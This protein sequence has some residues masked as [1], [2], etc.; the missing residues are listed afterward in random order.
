MTYRTYRTYMTYLTDQPPTPPFPIVYW[1]FMDRWA[2]FEPCESLHE[3]VLV[4]AVVVFAWFEGG[5]VLA[6]IVGRG[7][8]TPSGR[9]EPGE[10]LPQTAIR[11]TREETGAE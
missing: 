5:F 9:V 3:G 2:T 11:E 10:T 8:C 7:W 6:N 1:D 4:K